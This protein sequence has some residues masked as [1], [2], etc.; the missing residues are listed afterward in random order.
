MTYP[1]PS[2][3]PGISPQPPTPK[4]PTLPDGTPD[5]GR[6]SGQA[7]SAATGKVSI[8]DIPTGVDPNKPIWFDIGHSA[9]HEQTLDLKTG[10]TNDIASVTSHQIFASPTKIMRQYAALSANDPAA[11]VAVQKLLASGP[12]GTVHQTGAFDKYTEAALGS[13]MAQYLKL[14]HGAGVAMSFSEYLQKTAATAQALGGDGTSLQGST[15]PVINLT[16]PA[17]I[18]AA[19][20]SAFQEA[21]GKGADEKLLDSFVK[22]FQSAQTNAQLVSGGGTSSMPDLSSE[23]MAYAQKSDPQGFHD[24]QRT[25]FLDQL[26]NLLGGQRPNQTPVPGV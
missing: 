5:Y 16:D 8:W 19:A 10:R 20:Q 21:L 18:K 14:S 3:T 9:A 26:V 11:F 2:P 15:P 1:S 25:A 12:W 13:A 6:A 4:V 22:K 24:N 7:Q 17:E 23:A